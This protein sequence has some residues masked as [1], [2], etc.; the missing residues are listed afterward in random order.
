MSFRTLF[1]SAL[2]C[3]CG[4]IRA[5]DT[6][7]RYRMLS[8]E[9]LADSVIS[10]LELARNPEVLKAFFPP[11]NL[12]IQAADS[13]KAGQHTQ[14]L[15]ARYQASWARLKRDFKRFKKLMKEQRLSFRNA[16]RDTTYLRITEPGA[17]PLYA[18]VY[19]EYSRKKKRF[20]VRF[21]AVRLSGYWFLF[22][23]L[24]LREPD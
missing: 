4:S 6:A 20:L 17:R 24:Q 12:F 21:V 16:T 14:M 8:P 7:G 1:L 19:Q 18:Y 11:L 5:Q 23:D 10:K 3:L 13:V 22:S 15:V 9:A 2:L